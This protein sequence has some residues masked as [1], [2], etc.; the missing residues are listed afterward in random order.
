M[1]N[2]RTLKIESIV[3]FQ[4]NSPTGFQVNSPTQVAGEFT[5]GV[6]SE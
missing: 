4:V 2:F 1:P 3:T 6:A 5:P